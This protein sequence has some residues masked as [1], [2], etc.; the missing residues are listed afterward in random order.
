MQA[1]NM[2]APIYMGYEKE[3]GTDRPKGSRSGTSQYDDNIRRFLKELGL[4][5]D[6][7]NKFLMTP[8]A[9]HPAGMRGQGGPRPASQYA[10]P[11]QIGPNML[12]SYN[13]MQA[14]QGMH[15]MRPE[16]Y[17]PTSQLSIQYTA[18]D[19]TMYNM[20][21]VTPHENRGK[22][23]YNVLNG[24]YG[25]MMAEGKSAGYLGKAGK[26]GAAY[27][28]GSAYSGGKGGSSGGYSGGSSGSGGGGGK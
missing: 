24:L 10:L 27:A 13:P 28:G 26:G 19:G 18:P 9:S 23:L 7:E 4:D 14:M 1:T 20:G 16:G 5:E 22:A 8:T 17:G 3:N 11:S 25:L 12:N 21:V 15:Q 6:E 2:M